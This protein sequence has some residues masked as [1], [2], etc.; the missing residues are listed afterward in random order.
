MML[1]KKDS[2][3]LQTLRRQDNKNRIIDILK[4]V[5]PKKAV[6]IDEEVESESHPKMMGSIDEIEDEKLI[7]KKGKPI[8]A[9]VYGMAEV[10]TALAELPKIRK[11]LVRDSLVEKADGPI[12]VSN[13]PKQFDVRVVNGQKD[14][15]KDFP[16]EIKVSNFPKDLGKIDI[17][18]IV[19]GLQVVV[20]KLDDL[21]ND[22]NAKGTGG[23]GQSIVATNTGSYKEQ[24]FGITKYDPSSA[25]PT[26]IGKHS[27]PGALDSD[28]RWE[29]LK[30]T[31]SGTDVTQIVV[32][33]GAWE[34]RSSLF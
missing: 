16:K 27:D 25:T 8:K 23:N 22:I 9:T 4:G 10:I 6:P 5:A 28:D 20:D 30:Y 7:P 19:Q 1:P 34:N 29:I 32:R 33:K 2:S 24:I 12:E 3:L 14:D 21:Q 31:Y 11:I 26:Y 17:G 18:P 13:F 15:A